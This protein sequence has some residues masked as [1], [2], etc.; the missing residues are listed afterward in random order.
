MMTLSQAP[1]P[2]PVSLSLAERLALRS[3]VIQKCG[4]DYLISESA[5]ES[6]QAEIEAVCVIQG[7][8]FTG[9]RLTFHVMTKNSCT[10][11]QRADLESALSR[12]WG[13]PPNNCATFF[14]QHQ[15]TFVC[16]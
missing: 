12:K 8:E 6:I 4:Y 7:C 10:S 2:L 13:N 15:I 14:D 3:R 5:A 1:F 16:N 9:H 11:R